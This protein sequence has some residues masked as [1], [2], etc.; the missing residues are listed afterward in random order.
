[1]PDSGTSVSERIN[2]ETAAATAAV[3]LHFK[4]LR[5]EILSLMLHLLHGHIT[6]R[7]RWR[8]KEHSDPAVTPLAHLLP[9][10]DQYGKARLWK[11]I[12]YFPDPPCVRTTA[13]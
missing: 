1:L 10:L 8:S 4:A 9:V 2:G 5:R 12:C 13:G 7:R 11:L 6:V 3:V